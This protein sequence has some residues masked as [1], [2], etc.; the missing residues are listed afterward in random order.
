MEGQPIKL[1]RLGHLVMCSGSLFM[2]YLLFMIA[3]LSV[4][5]MLIVPSFVLL[6]L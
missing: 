1:S 6:L 5:Y 3:S 4:F 2:Q